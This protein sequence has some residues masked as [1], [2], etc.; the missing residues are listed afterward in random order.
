MS[1]LVMTR[2][3]VL[4]A[5]WCG[6]AAQSPVYGKELIAAYVARLSET[7]HFNSRGDRLTTAAA[8]IR[9]DRANY[10]LFNRRDPEDENDVFFA[11]KAN[12][13]RL[14]RLLETDDR[15]SSALRRIINGTPLVRIEIYR[16]SNGRNFIRV[17]VL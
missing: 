8:I 6:F 14:E 1:R 13:A 7:D 16:R 5:I 3:W 9:Q 12:R 15:T 10:H 11:R 2:W 17:V 4:L